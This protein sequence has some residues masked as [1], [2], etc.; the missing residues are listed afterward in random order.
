MGVLSLVMLSVSLR[1]LSL[2]ATRSRANNDS[3]STSHGPTLSPPTLL[4]LPAGDGELDLHLRSPSVSL[5]LRVTPPVFCST[6]MSPWIVLSETWTPPVFFLSF[7]SPST[8]LPKAASKIIN[9]TTRLAVLGIFNAPFSC[10]LKPGLSWSKIEGAMRCD[11]RFLYRQLSESCQTASRRSRTP[12]WRSW[13]AL[14]T[15]LTGPPI[16]TGS[17]ILDQC[18]LVMVLPV[19]KRAGLVVFRGHFIDYL[20]EPLV[21]IVMVRR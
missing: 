17:K 13:S 2:E 1:P 5:F 9:A 14:T 12:Q 18:E 7:I 6:F 11:G 3:M 10:P 16:T 20:L 15:N 21:A 19:L 8:T 4:P